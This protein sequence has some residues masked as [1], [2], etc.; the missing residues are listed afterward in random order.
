MKLPI[1]SKHCADGQAKSNESTAPCPSKF[2]IAQ[3]VTLAR[4]R[5]VPL[6]EDHAPG[7]AAPCRPLAVKRCYKVLLGGSQAIAAPVLLVFGSMP[8]FSSGFCP[9]LAKGQ[10]IPPHVLDVQMAAPAGSMERK[11]RG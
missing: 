5:Q 8:Y 6:E 10:C 9:S 3:D 2:N 1:Y 4:N 11:P 7:H